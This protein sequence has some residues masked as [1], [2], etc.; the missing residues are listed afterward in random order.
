MGVFGP[1]RGD[2][3][4]TGRPQRSVNNVWPE[5]LT[6]LDN[7]DEFL[8]AKRWLPSPGYEDQDG[9]PKGSF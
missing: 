4:R 7:A 2:R 5:E 1:S 6:S 9:A 8:A 3:S